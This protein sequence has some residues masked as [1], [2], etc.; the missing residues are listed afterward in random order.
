MIRIELQPLGR[1]IEVEPGTL[2][3]EPLDAF[4]V[5]FPCGGHGRC[6]GCRVRV[7][8]GTLPVSDDEATIFTPEEIA[9]GWRL[10][11]AARPAGNL[12]LEIGQW[13]TVILADH[14]T[15]AFTPRPGL[16]V[17]VDLGTTTL[18]A[19]LLDLQSGHVL[20]V[21][22]AVNPQTRFGSDVMNR[23]QAALEG[24]KAELVVAARRGVGELVTGVLGCLGVPRDDLAEVLVV[25]NTVMHHL[26]CDLDIGPLAL[27]PFETPDR[28]SHRFCGSELGWDLPGD[29]VVRFL[30][31][32]GSFVGSDILAGVIATG[33]QRRTAP[34]ILVDLGTNGEIVVGNRE[35]MLFASTAAGPAF[36]GGRISVGMRATTGAIAEVSAEHGKLCCRVLGGVE[37]R[38]LCGSG[39]VDAVAAALDLGLILPSGRLA[40]TGRPLEL[41]P[42]VAL[43]QGDIRQLQLAK[44]AIAAGV[45]IL[46][47]RFGEEA[48]REAPIYLAGA[49][50]NYVN[51]TSARRIGLI[52]APE[53]RIQAA[54]N[55]ALLGAKMALFEDHG[56]DE[57]FTDLRGRMEHVSLA[58]DPQFLEIFVQETL[59]PG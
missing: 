3:H 28:E 36:E 59:F 52:D 20:A 11:C 51:R 13:E 33:M 49:F 46:R 47:R 22:T 53:E 5:E 7:A 25:G 37:P 18:V 40:E 17:A 43:T 35:R 27:A 23:I 19:Q 29:P 34:A 54:G 26:F 14:S 10:A 44:G 2:L 45:K 30:P 32:L 4:G 8:S 39:L 21:R 9:D 6:G 42:P 16:G 41:A 1:T 31:C 50:G 48:C 15:F 12:T 24:R 58:T 38:G 57:D 55:T 56:E